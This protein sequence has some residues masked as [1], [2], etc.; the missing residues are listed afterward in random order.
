MSSI[1][2]HIA[3]STY[4]VPSTVA[5]GNMLVRVGRVGTGTP[6]ALLVASQHG[7]EGPW[8]TRAIR[9]LLEATPIEELHGSLRIVPIANPMAFEENMRESHIDRNDLNMEFPGDPAGQHTQ[10][11]ADVLRVNAV[12]GVDVVLDVHGGGSWCMN[13]FV[14]RFP[15]SHDLA[16]WIGGPFVREGPSRG[17]TS[18]TGSAMAQGAKAVWIEMGGAG[19][20]EERWAQRIA[21]GLRRALGKT[22]VMTAA[23][24][25]DTAPSVLTGASTSFRA[26]MPGLYLPILRED[27]VATVVPSGTEIGRLLDAVMNDVIETYV[28]PY[29]KTA[30]L[31]LRPRLGVVE[32]GEMLG[33]VANVD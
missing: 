10:R 20:H 21:D 3:W 2:D 19:A 12:D 22:G 5:N 29:P 33:V 9:K 27:G 30:M 31:L 25:P 14:Y 23:N 15:G 28:A 7:D 6:T 13:C 1:V 24:L 8:G 26:S 17:T 11:L 4:P 16:D 18:L 32:G